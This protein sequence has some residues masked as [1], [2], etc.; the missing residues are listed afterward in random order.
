M[1]IAPV[2]AGIEASVPVQ[3]RC[4]RTGPIRS[5]PEKN[6]CKSDRCPGM[7]ELCYEIY[8]RYVNHRCYKVGV[9]WF[10]RL[11]SLAC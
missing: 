8:D 6:W 5:F 4:A 11:A 9:V 2:K 7:G 3:M 1:E 10:C